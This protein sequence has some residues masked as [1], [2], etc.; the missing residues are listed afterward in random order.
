MR[1]PRR[2]A[3]TISRRCG[4]RVCGSSSRAVRATTRSNRRGRRP[5]AVA[6][7]GGASSRIAVGAAARE[8]AMQFERHGGG[9]GGEARFSITEVRVKLTDDPRN[10][11]KAYASVTIDDAFV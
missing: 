1:L 9:C 5:M 6:R 7:R 4:R 2:A 8:A 11:L 10:K 3:R